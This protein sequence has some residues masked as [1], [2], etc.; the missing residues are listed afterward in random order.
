VLL[1]ARRKEANRALAEQFEGRTADKRYLAVVEGPLAGKGELAHWIAPGEEGA[2]IAVPLGGRAPKGAQ[3]ARSSYR[4][5]TTVG[6]RRLVELTLD[7]GRT[8]QLRA[9]LAA[10]GAPIVGDRLYGGAPSHRLCLHAAHLALRHPTTGARV[11]FEAPAPRDLDDALHARPL[12]RPADPSELVHALRDAFHRRQ[13]LADDATTAIR[14]VNEEGDGLP[15]LSVD[16]YGEHAVASFYDAFD[17]AERDRIAQAMATLGLRGTYLKLRP[18]HASRLGDSRR[19]DVAPSEP[20]AGEPAPPAITIVEGG[21]DYEA[22]LGDGLSTGLFLDQRDNRRRV[23]ELAAGAR[24]LNLFAY[25]GSF[26]VVAAL[27]GARS[28]T[29]VDVSPTVLAWAERNL[30][31][32][33]FTAP[34]HAIVESDVF[35]YLERAAQRGERFDLV[36]L[37]PPSFSTTKTSRFSAESA[38][39]ELAERTFRVLAP[40]GRLLACTNHRGL[41]LAKFR[42]YLHEAARAAGVGVAQMKSLPIPTDFPPKPGLEPHLKCVLVTLGGAKGEHAEPRAPR[43]REHAGPRVSTPARDGDNRRSARAPRRAGPPPK[44]RPR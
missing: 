20:I 39:R 2:M 32:H 26:S 21:V 4:V 9:Q 28:T 43:E 35:A 34:A 36:V 27:G 15:G 24:M 40:A 41:V 17:D 12:A 3:E 38:Y 23:R 30:A 31:R 7:T 19:D 1:F 6:A 8:H 14:L 10:A 33:G 18:K 5:L 13:G 42:R 22:H 44:G 16:L 29:T 37:D 11:R 25:T